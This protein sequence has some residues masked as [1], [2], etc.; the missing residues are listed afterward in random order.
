MARP[1]RLEF[2]GALYHVTARGDRREPIYECDRDRFVFI[3]LLAREVQQQ[4]W[5]LY[6]YCLMP[7]HYHLLVE[8]PEAN[9]VA[10]MRR[11]NGAYTQSFNRRHERVGHVLQGRYKAILVEKDAHLLELAR[12]VVLNPVRANLVRDPAEYAWSSL[13]A[14]LGEIPG[15]PWLAAH[16]LLALFGDELGRAR[17]GYLRFV[18]A[19]IGIPTPW[20]GVRGQICL[21]GEA[22][23]RHVEKLAQR[24]PPHGIP[25]E[26]LHPSRPTAEAVL[27][28]VARAYR[29][30]RRAVLE[31]APPAA[32]R[33]A[34]YLLRRRANLSLCEVARCAGISPSRVSQIQQEIESVAPA[35]ALRAAWLE[36]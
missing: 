28:A 8:T 25:C 2:P 9:L 32:F 4:H 7:N 14:T 20:T 30:S 18:A 35:P 27:D 33:H 15:P 3:D 17:A 23:L 31:K 5:L 22:F 13:R 26:Q 34:V 16:R 1:L 10:G 6:A 21:G 24:R 19:G 36:L 29:I 11:L 12:Y